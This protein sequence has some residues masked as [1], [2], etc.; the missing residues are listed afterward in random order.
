MCSVGESGGG[1]LL[2]KFDGERVRAFQVRLNYFEYGDKL[3]PA[4][5]SGRPDAG[6]EA[7]QEG[8]ALAPL[9]R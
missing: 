5:P 4:E 7:L 1:T 2:E 3:R 6:V 9:F 8:S